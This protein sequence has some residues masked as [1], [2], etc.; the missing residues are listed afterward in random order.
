MRQF[1]VWFDS[2]LHRIITVVYNYE[3]RKPLNELMLSRALY[4]NIHLH[5]FRDFNSEPDLQHSLVEEILLDPSTFIESGWSISNDLGTDLLLKRHNIYIQTPKNHESL[6][7]DP[8]NSNVL[9]KRDR[10]TLAIMPAWDRIVSAHGWPLPGDARLYLPTVTH[11]R[12]VTELVAALDR[13]TLPWHIKT[14]RRDATMRPDSVVLYIRSADIDDAV[15]LV[16]SVVPKGNSTTRIPGFSLPCSDTWRIGMGF[17]WPESQE[18]SYGWSFARG[19]TKS[20]MRQ[21]NRT[22]PLEERAKLAFEDFL[23]ESAE[24]KSDVKIPR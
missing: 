9:I 2:I 8:E 4:F 18:A 10:R 7:Y 5:G 1:D 13:S 6:I 24:R 17:V 22:Q 20:L 21:S 19:L 23:Q 11:A 15:N 14:T 12:A 3:P 16:S